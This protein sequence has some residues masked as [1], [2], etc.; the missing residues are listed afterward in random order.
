[1]TPFIIYALPRSRTYWLSRYLTYG[2]WKC[3]HEQI[4]HIRGLDDVKSLL[5]MPFSGTAETAA[6]PFWRLI[7]KMRPDIKAVVIRRPVDEVIESLM[8]TGL[9]F[10]RSRLEVEIKKLDT[11]LDQIESRVNNVVSFRFDRIDE[12]A[13]ALLMNHCLGVDYEAAH[14]ARFSGQH[15][16]CDL[17]ALI[18][19][20][21][22]HRPQ[23]ERLRQQ[24]KQRMLAAIAARSVSMN[25]GMSFQQESLSEF[26]AGG[27]SLFRQ[28][29]VEVGEPLAS[30]E[31]KNI[32]LMYALENAGALHITTARCNGRMFGYLMAIISPALDSRTGTD[33]THTLFYGSPDSP[34][35]GLKLQKA[36]V[37]F[38]RSLGVDQIAMR[39]GTRGTGPKQ[40]ALFRR[41]GAE[42]VGDM[43]VLKMEGLS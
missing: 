20:F 29:A 22:A 34:G 39:A 30:W 10:D 16:V 37:E 4:R 12:S 5:D 17:D 38:L 40:S 21:N 14:Y 3:G 1:M 18:R 33:A 32:P 7:H 27:Q 15:L 41:M 6:A 25:S 42:K 35:V 26:I 24:V 8:A 23:L 28:H 31:E 11:K 2:Q 13:C 43:F 9:G 36:S 19:Y